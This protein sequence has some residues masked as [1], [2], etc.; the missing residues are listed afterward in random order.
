MKVGEHR[1]GTHRVA[2]RLLALIPAAFS[3]CGAFDAAGP[4]ASSPRVEISSSLVV[5]HPPTDLE[6]LSFVRLRVVGPDGDL[7]LEERFSDRAPSLQPRDL[8]DG[9][10]RYEA[11]AYV[12]VDRGETG[13]S[14]NPGR[15]ALERAGKAFG[16]LEVVGGF[17]QA[18][19]LAGS[20]ELTGGVQ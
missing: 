7:T 10:Y 4:G 3:L 5:F 18:P 16:V 9:F 11:I 14:T 6:N 19:R 1:R 12:E 2:I 20:D 15:A 17:V 8:E 13:D